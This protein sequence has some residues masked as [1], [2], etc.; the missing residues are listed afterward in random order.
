MKDRSKIVVGSLFGAAAIHLTMLACSGGGSPPER[1]AGSSDAAANEPDRTKPGRFD[2]VV[3]AVR[4]A[5]GGD[6]DAGGIDAASSDASKRDDRSTSGPLDAVMDAV[7]DAFGSVVDAEVRDAHAGGDA[8]TGSGTCGCLPPQPEYTVSFTLTGPDGTVARPLPGLTTAETKVTRRPGN[9]DFP[10]GFVFV[11]S[12]ATFWTTYGARHDTAQATL[13]CTALV[14][15]NTRT[16][17]PG[18]LPSCGLNGT[19]GIGPSNFN[20]SGGMASGVDVEVTTLTENQVV[21]RIPR[22]QLSSGLVLTG[23]SFRADVPGARFLTPID[24]F[25]TPGP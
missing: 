7:R 19:V 17:P 21:Y 15:F 8:G 3:D 11:E 2:A 18:L 22:V 4:D 14:R 10:T 23:V 6:E 20:F 24:A 1:D 5:L 9:D 12:T 25:R 13:R 16:L